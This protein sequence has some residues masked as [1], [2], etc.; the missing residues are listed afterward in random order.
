MAVKVTR[1]DKQIEEQKVKEVQETGGLSNEGV[2]LVRM[3]QRFDMIQVYAD[4][5]ATKMDE[6]YKD[7]CSSEGGNP[8][9]IMHIKTVNQL[10][11]DIDA[12]IKEATTTDLTPAN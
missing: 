3:L 9:V 1:A 4:S 8:F 7:L 6:L 2:A 11:A 5:I 10:L 12:Q